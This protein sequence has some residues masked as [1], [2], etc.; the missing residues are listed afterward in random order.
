[1]FLF[2]I[3]FWF[4]CT[5]P[6][7]V[8]LVKLGHGDALFFLYNTHIISNEEIAVIIYFEHKHTQSYIRTYIH[9]H[10]YTHTY[11]DTHTHTH[12]A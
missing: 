1:M 12:T 9:S 4:F 11:I 5:I 3:L 8:R 10:T 6:S 2:F 7:K